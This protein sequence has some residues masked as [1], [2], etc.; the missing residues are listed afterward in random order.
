MD[1]RT[2]VR[3]IMTGEC[4]TGENMGMQYSILK[5]IRK[6]DVAEERWTGGQVRPEALEACLRTGEYP[7]GENR[8]RQYGKD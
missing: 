1:W 5:T 2:D 8:G 6:V 4:L 3:L 7:T